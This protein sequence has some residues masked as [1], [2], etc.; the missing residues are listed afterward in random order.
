MPTWYTDFRG[1]LLLVQSVVGVFLFGYSLKR[2]EHMALRLALGLAVCC[3]VVYA[4]GAAV[5]IPGTEPRA[6]LTH[7]VI[8]LLVYVLLIGLVYLCFEES[9][10]TV[11]FVA[12][13]GYIA[14][15]LAG[16]FKQLL[17][18]IPG[19][20]ELTTQSLGI[21]LVDVCCYGAIFGLLFVLF[22]PATRNREDNFDNKLKAIV[23]AVVL[24]MCIGMARLTQ[25]NPERN[26]M[27]AVAESIYSMAVDIL[28]LVV[29]FNIMD[30][31]RLAN[32]VE[33]M[34]ELM[35]QQY[36]QY[37][38]SKA[39]VELIHEKYHDLKQM[40]AT[41]EEVVPE[42]QLTELKES[43]ERYETRVRSGYKVLDVLLTQKIDLCIQRNIQ[44]TVNLGN[45]DFS[46]ME[47]MDVY[48]LFHN[49]LNN[50]IRAVSALPE[51]M[52]RFIILLVRQ[53]G[54][55]LT[56][57]LE[58]PCTEDISFENGL[59]K[60]RRDARYHGFGMRS[61]ERTAEKYDGT[62]AVK[63]ENGKFYLDILMVQPA[64]GRSGK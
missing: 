50:A 55:L 51:D 49:A 18:Q 21:V 16:S 32:W 8:P 17:K 62:L 64:D 57:H 45:A 20:A 36:A 37:E 19:I 14:Q 54:N 13:S 39:T 52:F 6:V 53:E 9:M 25:D 7:A 4:V 40:I 15:D 41:L 1:A 60:S 43:I 34:Q 29:Q 42:H 12:S 61:M 33:T 48:T 58:N 2:R 38:E 47:E 24:I 5:Y 59:P 22:R 27:A 3:A 44:M 35:H 23:S 26:T 28:F 31:S 30:R 56:I 11:L 46:F 10:W 63:A